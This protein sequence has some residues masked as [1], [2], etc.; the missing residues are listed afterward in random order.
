ML[1]L[2]WGVEGRVVQGGEDSSLLEIAE[3]LVSFVEGYDPVLLG[4]LHLRTGDC[5]S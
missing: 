4:L 2:M 5:L 1:K 3:S